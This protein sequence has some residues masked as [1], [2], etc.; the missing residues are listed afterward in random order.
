MIVDVLMAMALVADAHDALGLAADSR[1][2]DGSRR[3]DRARGAR[4]GAGHDQA[5]LGDA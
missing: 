4:A 2:D 3:R 1:V 5:V